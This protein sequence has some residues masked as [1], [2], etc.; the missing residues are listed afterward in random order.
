MVPMAGEDAV[1]DSSPIKRKPQVRAA[2]VHGED[3]AGMGKHSDRPVRPANDENSSLFKFRKPS[4]VN[5]SSIHVRLNSWETHNYIAYNQQTSP[6]SRCAT[7]FGIGRGPRSRCIAPS[8]PTRPAFRT[9]GGCNSHSREWPARRR[10]SGLVCR[11]GQR[12]RPSLN[13]GA[14]SRRRA[15]LCDSQR[16]T[17]RLGR[18]SN[19]GRLADCP[20]LRRNRRAGRASRRRD[21]YPPRPWGLLSRGGPASPSRAEPYRPL[22]S[23]D[24]LAHNR[25][26]YR[27]VRP[28]GR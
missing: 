11:L 13:R 4:D 20:R 15:S 17:S 1:L 16:R 19:R 28:A 21:R 3:F 18:R 10:A 8:P 23:D 6:P 9:V 25:E 5:Q 24:E 12:K 7:L 22:A 14:R 2:I 26:L 27:A